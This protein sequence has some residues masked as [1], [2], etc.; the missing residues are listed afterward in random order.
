MSAKKVMTGF[1]LGVVTGIL[2]APAKGTETR[3]KIKRSFDDVSDCIKDAVDSVK[4]SISDMAE[5][6]INDVEQA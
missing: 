4:D 3:Q 1:L 5:E 6:D 2:L